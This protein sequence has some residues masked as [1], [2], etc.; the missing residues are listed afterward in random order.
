MR[1]RT[2]L[3]VNTSLEVFTNWVAK[4]E[5]WGIPIQSL[6]E[7][8]ENSWSLTSLTRLRWFIR[9]PHLNVKSPT[10][11]VKDTDLLKQYFY[12]W[13]TWTNYR[14][15]N[16]ITSDFRKRCFDGWLCVQARV[17][18]CQLSKS[19]QKQDQK[20]PP[21]VL[22]WWSRRAK[23]LWRRMQVAWVRSLVKKI[24][25]TCYNKDWPCCN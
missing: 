16:W 9:E 24:D 13:L 14:I 3:E 8:M 6:H 25:P 18:K 11:T 10:C 15:N 19:V 20:L 23:T 22:P 5:V 17:C 2:S 21:Q 12:I 1:L 7:E 4:I